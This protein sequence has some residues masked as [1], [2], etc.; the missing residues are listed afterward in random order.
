MAEQGEENIYTDNNTADPGETENDNRHTAPTTLTEEISH[1]L[2]HFNILPANRE[3]LPVTA[4]TSNR[5]SRVT[6]PD[7]KG[8]WD[9]TTEAVQPV[10]FKI[11]FR[12]CSS[13]CRTLSF[14]K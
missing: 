10:S 4:E 5:G 1:E 9:V 11:F 12:H 6:Q 14:G 7:D 13:I 8:D 2:S 3:S